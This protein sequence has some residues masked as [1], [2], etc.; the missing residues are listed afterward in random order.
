MKLK[1]KIMMA[2]VGVF[3]LAA[4]NAMAIPT[5]NYTVAGNDITFNVSNDLTG[6]GIYEVG[7]GSSPKSIDDS[8]VFG[9]DSVSFY[10]TNTP[11][12][13]DL[14]WVEPPVFGPGNVASI[15]ITYSTVEDIPYY[16]WLAGE[17]KM[18]DD[19]VSQY[20]VYYAGESNDKYIYRFNGTLPT[21][22]QVPEPVSLIILGLGLVGIAGLKKKMNK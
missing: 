20:G 22:S 9:D 21:A 13:L 12:N 1:S 3:F 4:G 15:K 14:F 6:Y 17:I 2:V 5:I 11:F 8:W 10:M 7:F 19:D 16:I 18:T